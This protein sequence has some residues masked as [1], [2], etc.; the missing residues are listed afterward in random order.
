MLRGSHRGP[1]HCRLQAVPVLL[2]P[3][4]VGKAWTGP[5]REWVAGV[6]GWQ[7]PQAF[8]LCQGGQQP[9]QGWPSTADVLQQLCPGLQLPNELI[10]LAYSSLQAVDSGFGG[11]QLLL[12]SRNLTGRRQD[13]AVTVL[14]GPEILLLP[15]PDYPGLPIRIKAMLLTTAS[16][17]PCYRLNVFP[18]NSYVESLATPRHVMYLEMEPLGCVHESGALI[19]LAPF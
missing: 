3:S 19:E 18:Q 1:K 17:P 9:G 10:P 11:Q 5:T 15:A 4:A 12:E 2:F 13:R 16:R 14:R 6:S 7:G 8:S